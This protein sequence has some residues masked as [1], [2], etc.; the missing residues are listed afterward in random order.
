M[1]ARFGIMLTSAQKPPREDLQCRQPWPQSFAP[2]HRRLHSFARSLR[3][4]HKNPLAV[5]AAAAVF[6]IVSC[7]F[8]VRPED[9]CADIA[10]P[11]YAPG[12]FSKTSQWFGQCAP[13]VR[14]LLPTD[15]AELTKR[16]HA[17]ASGSISWSTSADDRF[18]SCKVSGWSSQ[19]NLRDFVDV[20]AAYLEERMPHFITQVG[21][22]DARRCIGASPLA[23]PILISFICRYGQV[24]KRVGIAAS[25]IPLRIGQAVIRASVEFQRLHWHVT[26]PVFFHTRGGTSLAGQPEGY[27]LRD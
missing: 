9:L 1:S 11:L 21:F 8:K 14:R 27:Q 17:D 5:L 19:R 2:V 23:V 10:Q 24:Y 13:S 26:V 15:L 3:Q 22:I 18:I 25:G 16:T 12:Q 7:I 20:I 4:R 6:V